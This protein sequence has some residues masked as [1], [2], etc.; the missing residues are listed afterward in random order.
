MEGAPKPSREDLM[1]GRFIIDQGPNSI[2]VYLRNHES[3]D[4]L[5]EQVMV[6]SENWQH[7]VIGHTDAKGRILGVEI[8]LPAEKQ[9]SGEEER[10]R[11]D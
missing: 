9:T 5:E 10:C 1:R 4:I 6:D 3:E 8:I 2:Y 7:L 11:D